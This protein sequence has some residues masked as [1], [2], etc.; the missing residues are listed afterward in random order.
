MWC[1]FCE[2]K[3]EF[4]PS[5][6]SYHYFRSKGWVP[7]MG[8][9]YG[10]DLGKVSYTIVCMSV[11]EVRKFLLLQLKGSR[12]KMVEVRSTQFV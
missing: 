8:I 7:K 1:A 6:V 2:A 10:T 3:Q 9:K 12:F 11:D 5:Y 4:I